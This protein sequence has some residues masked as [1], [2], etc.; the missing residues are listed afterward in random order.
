MNATIEKFGHPAT[1]VADY[2]HWTVLL[3]PAQPVLGALVLTVGHAAYQA[4]DTGAVEAL[5][6]P[7]G[8]VADIRGVWRD[9]SFSDAVRIWRL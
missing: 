2:D 8:L 6:V 4:W 1:L 9:R 7:G 3:R 5:L